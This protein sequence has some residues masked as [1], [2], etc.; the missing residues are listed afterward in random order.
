MSNEIKEQTPAQTSAPPRKS[1]PQTVGEAIRASHPLLI[2]AIAF[3]VAINLLMLTGPLYMLQIYDRVLSS[4]SVPTLIALTGLAIAAYAT[5]ALVDGVRTRILS[6]AGRRFERLLSE[7][8]VRGAWS[9]KGAIGRGSELLRDVEAIRTFTSG[10]GLTALLDLPFAPLFVLVIFSLH[11]LLGVFALVAITAL[12]V[13]A[14]LT[15]TLTSKGFAKA[16]ETSKAN[17]ARVLNISTGTESARAMGM[18]P[19]LIGQ[20]RSAHLRYLDQH[21]QASETAASLKA[22][23]KGLRMLVQSLILGLGAWLVIGNEMSPGGM[24][25]ASIILGRALAPVEQAL[26]AWSQYNAARAARDSI[27]SALAEFRQDAPHARMRLP[28]LQGE[29]M[30]DKLTYIP[31]GQENPIIS[32][33]NIRVPPG[34]SVGVLG[35]SGVGKSTLLR[36]LIGALPPSSGQIRFD[37]ADTTQ[38]DPQDLGREIGYLPQDVVLMNGTIS[39]NI[40]RFEPGRDEEVIAAAQ[41]ARVHEMILQLP[42]GYNTMLG[43]QGRALSAGQRQ[44][45]GLARAIFG[46]PKIL[47][48][49]EPNSNLDES[50]EAALRSVIKDLSAAGST[51]F[52]ATHRTAILDSLDALLVMAPGSTAMFGPRDQVLEQ[53]RAAAQKSRQKAARPAASSPSIAPA[54]ARKQQAIAP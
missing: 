43:D 25:A 3:G 35:P 32:S 6:R 49:D 24:I 41:R 8:L 15:Q 14:L 47:V 28:R 36:L 19:T 44:R 46:M 31:A 34:T 11:P 12:T 23:S 48:L 26:G 38:I 45:V 2:T 1:E 9:G 29:V 51:V 40:A 22:L 53:L 5:M 16:R 30:L 33:L 10:P 39:E 54:S 18:I 17:G 37:G 52:I 4:A 7:P 13:I 20:W 50:G 27:D 21:S 42:E